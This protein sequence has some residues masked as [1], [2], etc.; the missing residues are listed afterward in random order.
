MSEI[1][2]ILGRLGVGTAVLKGW[3][4]RK[5]VAWEE[6]RPCSRRSRPGQV[7]WAQEGADLQAAS[8]TPTMRQ[9]T[10][11]SQ[12]LVGCVPCLQRGM[13]SKTQSLPWWVRQFQE[14]IH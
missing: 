1:Q 9:P 10:S 7:A 4:E 14:G 6:T 2:N 8:G 13:M 3:R 11:V 5:A 12:A